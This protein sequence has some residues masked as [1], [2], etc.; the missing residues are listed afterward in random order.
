MIL[1][2]STRVISLSFLPS[3]Y[4][5][6]Q[7]Y[8]IPSHSLRNLFLVFILHSPAVSGFPVSSTRIF[9]VLS[10]HPHLS[11][12]APPLHSPYRFLSITI[13]VSSLF[14]IC[15]SRCSEYAN[16]LFIPCRPAHTRLYHCSFPSLFHLHLA[17]R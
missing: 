7:F 2:S 15:L 14:C 8:F 16:S 10:A 9:P 4:I 1:A 12:F 6:Q 13:S 11:Y 17:P 5:L 3:L